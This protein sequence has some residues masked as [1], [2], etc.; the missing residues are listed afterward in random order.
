MAKKLITEACVRGMPEGG[1]LHVG[2]AVIAT[3]AAVDLARD[4]GIRVEWGTG[5]AS[6]AP[7]QTGSGQRECLWHAMLAKDGTYVV[8]V[9]N[10]QAVV[11]RLEASGPTRFGTDSKETHGR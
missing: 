6:G 5:V 3:P 9:V 1:V 2:G 7:A 10:G 4:K 11:D 8:R